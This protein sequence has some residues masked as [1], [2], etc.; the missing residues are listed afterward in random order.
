[1]YITLGIVAGFVLGVIVFQLINRYREKVYLS[2]FSFELSNRNNAIHSRARYY[3]EKVIPR[4]ED[5]TLMNLP[6]EELEVMYNLWYE[7][8]TNKKAP[9]LSIGNRL[10]RIIEAKR[11]IILESRLMVGG[12]T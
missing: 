2:A 1:M 9:D 7:D 5:N 3:L 6:Y 8:L 12:Q 4:L 11:K 10:Y